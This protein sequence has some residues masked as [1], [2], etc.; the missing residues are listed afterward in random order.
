MEELYQGKLEFHRPTP[1]ELEAERLQALAL[2]EARQDANNDLDA[3]T[4][5][6]RD[7]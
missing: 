7:A 6:L 3:F 2:E 5:A 1:E 4:D